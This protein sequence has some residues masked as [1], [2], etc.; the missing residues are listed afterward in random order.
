MYMGDLGNLGNTIRRLRSERNF[1]LKE[2]SDKTVR[3]EL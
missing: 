2:L 3:W 1:T